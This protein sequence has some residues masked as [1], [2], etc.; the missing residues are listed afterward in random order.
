[1]LEKV[2]K[3]NGALRTPGVKEVHKPILT[4]A[5]SKIRYEIE[6]QVGDHEDITAAESQTSSLMMSMLFMMWDI[7][8]DEQKAR[9]VP[10]QKGFI[11]Y[12][13][14]KF[15]NTTTMADI[16]FAE[17]GI[18]EIDKLLDRQGDIAKIV[19]DTLA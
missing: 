9:L 4:D 15:R 13:R 7:M 18:S 11:D 19:K 14:E 2:T 1:M 16:K 17:N 10:E 5:K 8:S 12:A 6:K 3:V